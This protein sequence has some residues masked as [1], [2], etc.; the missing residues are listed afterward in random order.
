MILIPAKFKAKGYL[1]EQIV[2][3][4]NV[5]IFKRIRLEGKDEEP[6]G[7]VSF[8][9][10]RINRHNGYEL[11]GN[12]I[13][14]AETYPG[15]SAWGRLALS[16]PTLEVAKEQYKRMQEKFAGKD[17]L[18]GAI[19]DEGAESVIVS[20][21]DGTSGPAPKAGRGRKAYNVEIVIPTDKAEF[22]LKDVEI[23]N[24]DKK[25][26][27]GYIYLKLKALESANKIQVSSKRKV[28]GG[29]GRATVFYTH[30]K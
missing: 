17:N 4:N 15:N 25:V 21:P 14:P 28:S 22:C 11:G 6:T 3:E 20:N 27:G 13:K 30:V 19:K 29:K 8:E 7:A 1:F 18:T 12:Y 2:R 23:L 16:A 24:E 10:V 26:S 9:V 5:A